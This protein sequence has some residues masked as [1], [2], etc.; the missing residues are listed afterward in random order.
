MI[1]KH[2]LHRLSPDELAVLLYCVN[3]GNIESPKLDE[4]NI[5]CARESF[6]FKMLNEFAAKLTSEKKK[7]QMQDI[8]DKITNP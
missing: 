8:A 5:H 3:E 6:A 2:K 4:T 1:H 7:K